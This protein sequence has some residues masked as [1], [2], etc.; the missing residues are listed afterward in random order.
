MKRR[1]NIFCDYCHDGIL[2]PVIRLTEGGSRKF[3]FDMGCAL[4][5]ESRGSLEI[6]GQRY[7]YPLLPEEE[8]YG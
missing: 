3:N 7:A 6:K 4:L 1:S 5:L 8:N 2:N